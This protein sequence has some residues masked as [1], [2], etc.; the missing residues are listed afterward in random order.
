[1]SNSK[2][3]DKSFKVPLNVLKHIRATLVSHPHGSGVKRA[4]YVLK[5][6]VLSYSA[7]KR[8]KNYFDTF[9]SGNDDRTQYEL[10]GGELMK[11]FIDVTLNRERDGVDRTKEIRR[12]VDI[13]V[14]LGTKA[15]EAPRLNEVKKKVKKNAIAIIVND[16]NKFLLLKRSSYPKQWM[17][18]KWALIGGVIEKNETPEQGCKREVKE[19]TGLIIKKFIKTFKIQR[20]SDNIEHVFACR[21]SGDPSDV[22][23]DEENSNYGWFDIS[24]INYLD[25]VPNINEY[26]ALAFKEYE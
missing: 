26:I 14:N 15:F 1:M 13:D 18:N 9:N 12:D 25:L 7:I 6:G 19:E 17:P 3:Y 5:N 2:L 11:S 16:D 24:E 21:Y 8:L 10:A 22:M 20:S 23:L 4:K